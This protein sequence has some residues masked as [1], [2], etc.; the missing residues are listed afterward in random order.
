M[1]TQSLTTALAFL[2][3]AFMWG[4][5]EQGSAPLGPEGLGVLLDRA[6]PHPHGDENGD[7]ASFT[8]TITGDVISVGDIGLLRNP[9]LHTDPGSP[10]VLDLSF[11]TTAL[12]NGSTCFAAGNPFTGPLRVTVQ[13]E[14]LDARITFDFTA[15]DKDGMTKNYQLGLVGVIDVLANWPAVDGP[16]TITG[17]S[18]N[19]HIGT[20]PHKIACTGT[21]LLS[22]IMEVTRTS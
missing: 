9:G 8:A 10:A 16:S 7:E 5:Q 14:P 4:C 2:V 12:T 3:A 6:G 11:F 22:F 17:E 15:R 1:K 20:G 19:M 13:K 18:F 21:G